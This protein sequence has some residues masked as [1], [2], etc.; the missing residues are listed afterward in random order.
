LN[1]D[2]DYLLFDWK[3]ED[4]TSGFDVCLPSG[5][6]ASQGLALSR[7]SGVPSNAE[8]W[9]HKDVVCADSNGSI[10][11]IARGASLGSVGWVE[12]TDYVFKFEYTPTELRV[13]VGDDLEIDLTTPASNPFP[14]GRFCFYNYSQGM[15]RYRGFTREQVTSAPSRS[16]SLAPSSAPSSAP[17]VSE[18]PTSSSAPS[19]LPTVSSAPSSKPSKAPSPEPTISPSQAPSPEPSVP[20]SSTP[21]VSAGPSAEP[22]SKP[23]ASPVVIPAPTPAPVTTCE[24]C[25]H[26]LGG[27]GIRVRR[28][29]LGICIDKCT[30]LPQIKLLTGWECGSCP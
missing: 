26:I 24:R 5:G 3:Q 9:T 30:E 4:Q 8:M 19:A 16:P 20:P 11:E 7:V 29:I 28:T 10:Q 15:V 27:S 17:N 12:K 25:D 2:A 1:G 21:S 14:E 22:S 6:F 18:E 13:F 23:S